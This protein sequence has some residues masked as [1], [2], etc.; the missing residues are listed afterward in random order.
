[1]ADN[2]SQ[3]PAWQ[4]LNNRRCISEPVTGSVIQSLPFHEHFSGNKTNIEKNRNI[5]MYLIS[6]VPRTVCFAC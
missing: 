4:V 2:K 6:I 5:K 3:A 1:V